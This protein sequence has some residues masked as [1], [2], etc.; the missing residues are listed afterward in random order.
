MILYACMHACSAT[1]PQSLSLFFSFP[2]LETHVLMPVHSCEE[3]DRKA[4]A[5][6]RG[7]LLMSVHLLMCTCS[8]VSLFFV[9]NARVIEG[10]GVVLVD[11]SGIC[12]LC[13]C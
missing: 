9:P 7:M 1:F 12:A 5:C 10:V 6:A 4:R 8:N 11:D 2:F 13:V 3:A